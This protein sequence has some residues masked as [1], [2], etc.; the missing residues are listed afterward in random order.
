MCSKGIQPDTEDQR[1]ANLMLE[2]KPIGCDRARKALICR[3][4]QRR[5]DQEG[6]SD[7]VLSFLV[8]RLTLAS[9]SVLGKGSGDVDDRPAAEP[10][11]RTQLPCDCGQDVAGAR[12][13]LSLGRK[14]STCGT[15]SCRHWKLAFAGLQ[16]SGSN[17]SLL[18]GM[19]ERFAASP[20][21][22]VV[23]QRL[24]QAKVSV[25]REIQEH[26]LLGAQTPG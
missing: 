6:A 1:G 8:V 13:V 2:A 16:K 25:A 14:V 10:A 18:L 26:H 17:K 23:T 20:S 22:E 9:R 15:K 5:A 12:D 19:T 7:L 4:H 24:G 11:T 3:A 21:P